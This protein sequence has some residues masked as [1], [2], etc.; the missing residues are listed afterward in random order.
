M[1][2]RNIALSILLTGVMASYGATT[3]RFYLSGTD[4]GDTR[5]WD[6]YCTDGQRSKTKSKIEV[7]SCWEQQGFGAYTYGRFYKTEGLKPAKES[8]I[9][10]TSFRIPA[11][12][13]GK[14]FRLTFEGSMTDTH[15]KID[16]K[17]V[18]PAHQGGFTEFSF[19]V[20]PYIK[21]GKKQKLE[22]R[23]D[24][25]SSNASVNSAERRADWW[26]FG[27]IYRPVYIESLPTRHISGTSIDA[28]AGGHLKAIVRSQG[29]D[30]ETPL[31]IDLK[32]H[33][34]K[35]VKTVYNEKDHSYIIDADFP[36]ISTW[37]T[38]KPNLHDVTFTLGEGNDTHSVTERI[39]F[40]TIEFVPS[41][42]FYLNGKKLRVKGTNRHCFHPETGRA[43]NKRQN[44]EDIRLLKFMNMNAVRC[45]YPSDRHFLQLCDS[46]GILYFDEFPGW[47]THYD[48]TTA[49]KLLPDFINR[50][51]NHPS[52]FIWANGNEG[53]WNTCV[54]SL[55]AKYDLQKRRVVHPWS[56]FN[57]IDTHHYPAY[58]TGA[59]R[60]AKGR[61]VFM[62]TEF[63]HGQYDK[64]QGAALED[65]WDNWSRSPLFAGGFIWAFVDEAVRRT[66]LPTGKSQ[67]L[68]FSDR[69]FDI[70]DCI[71]DSDDSNGPDGCVDPYRQPEA[72]VFTIRE[73]WS[74]IY[75][76]SLDVIPNFDGRIAVENRWTSTS[77]K[78]CS[79]RY[80]LLTVN[81]DGMKTTG[82]GVVTLPAI[83]PGERGFAIFDLPE[84]F[85]DN[86]ILEVTAYAPDGSE[87]C[88]WT[89]YIR[90]PQISGKAGDVDIKVSFTEDGMI[91]SI[92]R[93][94]EVIPL[95]GGPL[96]VGMKS[97]CYSRTERKEADG[98]TITT[99]RYKGG[100]D[101]IQWIQ[102][103]DGKLEMNARILDSPNGHRY[104]GNFIT[105]EGKWQI[106]LTFNYPEENVDSVRWIGKGPYRVWRNREKG[107]NHGVWTKTY[108][109]TVTGQ[110]DS[111]QQPVYPEFKGHHAD[112]RYMKLFG[113]DGKGFSLSS[114]TEKMY[115]RLFTPEEPGASSLGEMGGPEEAAI[116]ARAQKKPERTMVKFPEGDISFL[117]SIP[118]MRSYKPLE[119]QGPQ[120][121]PDVIRI[122][123]GDDGFN[124]NLVFDF[125]E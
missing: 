96:P 9:Y 1:N 2:T 73:V 112:V 117:L 31:K 109:N 61:N 56:D 80:R 27:G 3:Q 59:Y 24:K 92:R 35:N 57:G 21:P 97:E 8:G 14:H 76:K 55:F 95:S 58:Q 84:N 42:G 83:E 23:V 102:R 124:I 15:V 43:I 50:D 115:V 120:S 118:P 22:V 18:A 11:S 77:L 125:N 19:D 93:N 91:E 72:S 13:A 88:T 108:N 94:G 25:E 12:E 70:K 123:Q 10:S 111:P 48:D 52:V 20:T 65:F 51:Q 103:P 69:K 101:S 36:G 114:D 4:S 53:G 106:G 46:A 122:K 39:G 105:E 89:D 71:L 26:L 44:E 67:G 68:K 79:M 40:R 33:T 99:F 17:E 47:Q 64:G 121:Q 87:V 98:T 110:Y 30:V 119:Q 45:H 6:F 66:D 41:D 32:G 104:P 29:A 81:E 5:T 62:P 16:G 78:E 82:E 100:I 90:T 107:M 28:R 7:P 75:I 49:M 34:A 85:R 37:S 86:D 54:D 116:R 74:P 60:L 63:L 113:K 38:E